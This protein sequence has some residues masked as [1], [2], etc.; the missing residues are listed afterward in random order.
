[1]HV[2]L[3]VYSAFNDLEVANDSRYH[4]TIVR[5]DSASYVLYTYS[6]LALQIILEATSA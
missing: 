6:A 3:V 1:M 4:W 5:T 2:V